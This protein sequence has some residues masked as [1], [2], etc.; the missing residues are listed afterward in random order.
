MYGPLKEVL[1]ETN[2]DGRP[3]GD[4]MFGEIRQYRTG[5]EIHM[6]AMFDGL[7]VMLPGRSDPITMG[8]T[9]GYDFSA[10]MR[11]TSK[12]SLRMG[13][14]RTLCASSPTRR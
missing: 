7:E 11:F 10:D 2:L 13:T 14:V 8:V 5:G 12:A 1:R 3:L 9:S 6:D 4:V